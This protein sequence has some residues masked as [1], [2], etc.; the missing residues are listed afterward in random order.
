MKTYVPD[1][2]KFEFNAVLFAN[3]RLL[4]AIAIAWVIVACHYGCGGALNEFL[5]MKFW[6][7]IEKVGLCLYLNHINNMIY[8][9]QLRKK[10]IDFDLDAIVRSS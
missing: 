10:P 3:D 8:F 9:T 1:I 2:F 6:M 5:S 7:P 4:W